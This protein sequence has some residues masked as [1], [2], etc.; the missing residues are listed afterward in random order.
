MRI[1]DLLMWIACLN[2]F[3]KIIKRRMVNQGKLYYQSNINIVKRWI[4]QLARSGKSNIKR[5]QKYKCK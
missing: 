5:I 4:K 3:L 2:V 1:L